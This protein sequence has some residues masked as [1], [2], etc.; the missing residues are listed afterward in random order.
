MSP[1][2]L[3]VPEL[4]DEIAEQMESNECQILCLVAKRFVVPS[5]RRIFR[6]ILLPNDRACE[7][8]YSLLSGSR[9]IAEYAR[10]LTIDLASVKNSEA[11]VVLDMLRGLKHFILTPT[12]PDHLSW[13]TMKIPIRSAISRVIQLSGIREL[14]LCSIEGFPS[15]LLR[16]SVHQVRHLVIYGQLTLDNTDQMSW[17]KPEPLTDVGPLQ[18]LEIGDPTRDSLPIYNFLRR[19]DVRPAIMNV[20]SIRLMVDLRAWDLLGDAQLFRNLTQLWLTWIFLGRHRD[21]VTLHPLDLPSLPSLRK[22]YLAVITD[23]WEDALVLMGESITLAEQTPALEELGLVLEPSL[24][25]SERSGPFPFF[26]DSSYAEKLPTLRRIKCHMTGDES[27]NAML[28]EF[29]EQMRTRFPAPFADGILT[30]GIL[31][32]SL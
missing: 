20:A 31:V 32:T 12:F 11:I 4:V 15:A 3:S 22:F 27:S 9:H 2:A 1:T 28:D 24:T 10:H 25:T 6:T 13:S 16:Y 5:Q 23:L 8:L 17:M 29:T 30:C 26:G 7:R 14:H 18:R 19:A 21:W